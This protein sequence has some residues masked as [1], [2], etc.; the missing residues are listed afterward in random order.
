MF[1]FINLYGPNKAINRRH[2]LEKLQNVLVSYDFGDYLIIGGDFNIVQDNIKDKSS[3]T[4]KKN[5]KNEQTWSQRKIKEIKNSYSLVDIW[6][7][8]K[9]AV[10]WHTWS[11][12]KPLVRCRLDYFLISERLSHF[13]IIPKIL[14]AMKTDHALIELQLNYRVHREDF[15]GLSR[16]FGN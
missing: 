7:Q 12:P 8:N 1:S 14:P 3:K 6:R 2:F 16:E 9:P 4:R 11:Q 13:S 15:G 5:M 10:K